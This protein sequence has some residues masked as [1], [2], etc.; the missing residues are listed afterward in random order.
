MR[1]EGRRRSVRG[2]AEDG[3]S[4]NDSFKEGFPSLI[5]GGMIAATL[6]P[7]A[8]FELSPGMRVAD[9][10]TT[11]AETRVV[12]LPPRVEVPPP[13]EVARPA[14]PRVSTAADLD[15]DETDHVRETRV[16]AGSGYDGLD[17]AARAVARRMEFSPAMNRDMKTAV[18][19]RQGIEFEVT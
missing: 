5:A 8:L 6:A 15:V 13:Q 3:S 2:S 7:F 9:I 12:E 18:W 4:A 17:R 11:T 16:K 14:T 19:V 10:R 1:S